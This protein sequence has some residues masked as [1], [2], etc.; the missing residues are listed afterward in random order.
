MQSRKKSAE[1]SGTEKVLTPGK[2]SSYSKEEEKK[3]KEISEI[4]FLT[5]GSVSLIGVLPNVIKSHI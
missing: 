2:V 1:P 3:K 5:C 4:F